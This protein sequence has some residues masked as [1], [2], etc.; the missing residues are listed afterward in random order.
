MI[1]QGRPLVS[2]QQTGDSSVYSAVQGLVPPPWPGQLEKEKEII[3][4]KPFK[5]LSVPL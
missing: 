2:V 3:K 4:T 5:K 1:D